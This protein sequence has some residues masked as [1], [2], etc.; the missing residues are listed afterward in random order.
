MKTK[1]PS[2]GNTNP[3]TPV[4]ILVVILVAI[5]ALVKWLDQ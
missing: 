2:E 4:A 1:Y 3:L 5:H